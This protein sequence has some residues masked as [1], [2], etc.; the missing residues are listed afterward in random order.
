MALPNIIVSLTS[1]PD[2][3]PTL[4]RCLGP[5]LRQTV[6]TDGI[7]LWLAKDDFVGIS[8]DLPASLLSLQEQGL[9]ICWCEKTLY[10]HDKYWWTMQRYPNATV[11]TVDDD[12]IYRTTLVQTLLDQH[13]LY[14]QAVIA[15]RTHLVTLDNAGEIAPYRQWRFEQT[16]LCNEP[17]NDLFATNGAG[18]LFPPRIF[19]ETVF[20]EDL[21][22]KTA[23]K[24]DDLWLK[25]HELRLGIE[26]VAPFGTPYLSYIPG[27][28]EEC[29][30]ND[31]INRND[32]YLRNLFDVYP[33]TRETLIQA[34]REREAQ[35]VEPNPAGRKAR[36][37]RPLS[38]LLGV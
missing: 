7:L 34:V 32:E 25:I 12:L 16:D 8:Q 17:R 10:C 4:A 11:I 2:R 31:N 35:K 18:T 21:V 5:L 19:D 15:N 3:L 6:K 28:Q 33:Q 20:D 36:L 23:L 26:I 1:Y 38:K 29:L 27:T 24:S 13:F 14:P 9:E 22:R 30:F 37:A